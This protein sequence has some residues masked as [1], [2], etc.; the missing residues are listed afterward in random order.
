M[1]ALLLFHGIKVDTSLVNSH[2]SACF[3]ARRCNAP[4]GDTFRKV[5]H[6]G[7]SATATF[8]HFVADVHQSIKKSA[9]GDDNTL[10]IKLHIPYRFNSN[11][12]VIFNDEFIDFVLPNVKIVSVVER[13]SPLPN[14][15]TSVALCPWTPH[16][17]T[18][19]D[20]Q[21]AE[22]YGSFIS[23]SAHLST[24][25][26]DFSNDLSL[27]NSTHSRI[28]THLT[29]LVHIHCYQAGFSPHAS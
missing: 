20:V 21:H 1:V 6:S 10:G 19:S 25:S 4:S 8:Y 26:I 5:V 23:Y 7:F 16:R 14:E 13:C 28:T 9:C 15:F 27:C 12:L 18:L 24:Q 17:G 29:Y 3:H 11:C 2:W 22:L